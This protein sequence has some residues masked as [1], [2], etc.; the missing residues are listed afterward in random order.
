MPSRYQGGGSHNGRPDPALADARLCD[1]ARLDYLVAQLPLVETLVVTSST[2]NAYAGDR[3][4]HL[5]R[6][7]LGILSDRF[8][9]V[10]ETVVLREITEAVR[11]L[12]I[13]TPTEEPMRRWRSLVDA[14]A[15]PYGIICPGVSSFFPFRTVTI[16]QRGGKMLDTLTILK[17]AICAARSASSKLTSFS[18][19]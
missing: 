1:V 4:Q 17:E 19:F 11:S 8:V 12:G 18:L 16:S 13:A 10:A 7:V 2:S 6:N 14:S 5:G 15:R 3:R 9:V